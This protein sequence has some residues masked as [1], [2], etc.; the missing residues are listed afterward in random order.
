MYFYFFIKESKINHLKYKFQYFG[1]PTHS[2]LLGTKFNK[3]NYDIGI[4]CNGEVIK[5]IFQRFQFNRT[6]KILFYSVNIFHF[7]LKNAKHFEL[8]SQAS[9]LVLKFSSPLIQ[10]DNC[11]NSP[12]PAFLDDFMFQ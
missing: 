5:H 12:A 1:F 11:Q 10:L 3:Q 2:Y 8:M 9:F 6:S 7:R 4:G